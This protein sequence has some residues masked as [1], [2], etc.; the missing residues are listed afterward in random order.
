MG[1]LLLPVWKFLFWSTVSQIQE[2]PD[3]FVSLVKVFLRLSVGIR[4][5]YPVEPKFGGRGS[6]CSTMSHW[7]GKRGQSYFL[8]LK[9]HKF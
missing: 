4:T 2:V 3:Y 7:D 9:S 8:V 6:T 5:S 1:H